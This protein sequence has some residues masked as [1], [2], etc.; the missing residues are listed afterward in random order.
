MTRWF[1]ALFLVVA[2]AAPALAQEEQI[3]QVNTASGTI[4]V[5]RAGQRLPLKIGDQIYRK[6][7]I[8]TGT[9]SSVGITFTD[10]SVISAGPDSRLVLEQF[11]FDS[12]NYRGDMLA[13]LQKGTLTA[14]SGD[15]A[16]SSPGAMKIETPTA[17]LGVRG[18]TFA[19]EAH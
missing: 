5:E 10:N 6:D 8:E 7:I 9:D 3:A 13:K 14:V 2:T 12:N 16:H 15:I 11:H 1:G 18:T 4:A 17:I 19:V